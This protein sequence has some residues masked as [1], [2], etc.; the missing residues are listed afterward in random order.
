MADGEEYY[1]GF[2]GGVNWA[3]MVGYKPSQDKRRNR[4]IGP[5][6]RI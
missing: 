1:S 3:D 6:S 5:S 2:A 4:H